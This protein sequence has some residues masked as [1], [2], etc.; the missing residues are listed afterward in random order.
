MLSVF[1]VTYDHELF[2]AQTLDSILM[3]KTKFDFDIIIGED[4]SKD[5]TASIL[6]KYESDFPKKIKVKYQKQNIGTIANVVDTLSRCN[7]KYIALCEGDDY[8]TDPLKLQKQVDFLEANPE[9]VLCCHKAVIYDEVNKEFDKAGNIQY[10]DIDYSSLELMKGERMFTATMCF[11]NIIEEFP[12]EIHLSKNG[13]VFL[14]ALLG[15]FGKGKFLKDINSA[16]YRKHLGGVNSSLPQIRKIENFIQTRM[17]M[18]NY[19]L[20]IGNLEVA[21][22]YFDEVKN[23]AVRSHVLKDD[24]LNDVVLKRNVYGFFFRYQKILFPI[25][26]FI[27]KTICRLKLW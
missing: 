26:D 17:N 19:F 13:D 5:K 3:Q 15:E 2:I 16:V 18:Y 20:R 4:C 11:R 7:G 10:E 27:Q 8:W 6:K 1:V 23:Y 24:L 21:N 22:H 12:Q 14:T 25:V 9:Y